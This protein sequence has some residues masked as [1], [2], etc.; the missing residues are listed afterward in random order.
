MKGTSTEKEREER[1]Q[2]VGRSGERMARMRRCGTI[3]R[4]Q[5]HEAGQMG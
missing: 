2:G 1:R 3:L 4:G 5:G